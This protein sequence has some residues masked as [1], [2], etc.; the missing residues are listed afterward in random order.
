MRSRCRNSVGLNA[1]GTS[2]GILWNFQLSARS[3]ALGLA[4]RTN[5]VGRWMIAIP[6]KRWGNRKRMPGQQ[7]GFRRSRRGVLVWSPDRWAMG[8]LNAPRRRLDLRRWATRAAA[9]DRARVYPP[10]AEQARGPS[11][12]P[13]RVRV[14]AEVFDRLTATA[15]RRT[16]TGREALSWTL[17]QA[18]AAPCRM[19]REEIEPRGGPSAWAPGFSFAKL[20]ITRRVFI[21]PRPRWRLRHDK[22]EAGERQAR[23]GRGMTGAR[24][25]DSR[26][27]CCGKTIR[28]MVRLPVWGKGGRRE[29]DVP[30]DSTGRSTSRRMVCD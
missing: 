30:A 5:G 10:S 15:G 18:P 6:V 24:W 13:L 11:G 2:G 7:T 9:Q 21:L 29:R 27:D 19:C 16:H 25:D 17:V 22:A 23:G 3:L 26:D 1:V 12:S 28:V 14:P 20:K 4:A 8:G